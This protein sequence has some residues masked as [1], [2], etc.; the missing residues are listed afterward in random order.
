MQM[1]GHLLPCFVRLRFDY[2]TQTPVAFGGYSRLAWC[3][4]FSHAL[5]KAAYVT[6]MKTCETCPPRISCSCQ[7]LFENPPV[8]VAQG[9]TTE[10]PRPWVLSVLGGLREQAPRFLHSLDLTAIGRGISY[11]PL[12]LRIMRK[13]SEHGVGNPQ[14]R[15]MLQQPS[16]FSDTGREIFDAIQAKRPQPMSCTLCRAVPASKKTRDHGPGRLRFVF[17]SLRAASIG[18]GSAI[19]IM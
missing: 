7:H 2:S 13:T 9:V 8:H 18:S 15:L 10:A 19:L 5:R 4:A 11:L 6:G 16:I 12:I 3:R 14:I 17:A 1:P